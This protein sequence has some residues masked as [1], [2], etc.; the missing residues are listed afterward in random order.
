MRRATFGAAIILLATIGLGC[1]SETTPTPLVQSAPIATDTITASSNGAQPA[2]PTA[3][4][5]DVVIDAQPAT[6][7]DVPPTIAVPT[8]APPVAVAAVPA[9]GPD[10]FRADS[11]NRIASSGRPQLV[12]VF[13]YW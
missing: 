2:I 12:E 8:D 3:T 6:A 9:A 5:A 10:E 13:A 4:A 11:A 7:T 1:S